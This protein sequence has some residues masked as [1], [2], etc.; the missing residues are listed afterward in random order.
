MK[1]RILLIS[2]VVAF[3]VII[4]VLILFLIPSP[5]GTALKF[6]SELKKENYYEM[7]QI[8][9]ISASELI[10]DYAGINIINYKIKNISDPVKIKH[11]INNTL[12]SDYSNL[13]NAYNEMLKRQNPDYAVIEDT[14]TS[15]TL[16]SPDKYINTYNI[17]LDVEY[18]TFTGE[19]RRSSVYIDIQQK[20]PNSNTYVVTNIIGL[21]NY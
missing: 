18:S 8:S 15:F 4:A 12:D 21:L 2:S 13:F 7:G 10:D 16:E 6:M 11:T 17:T 20:E 9:T 14:D 1:K 5:R 3:A 19:Q